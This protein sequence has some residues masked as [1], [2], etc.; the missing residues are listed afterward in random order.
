MSRGS[1]AVSWFAPETWAETR[2]A[3]A[4][5]DRLPASHAAWA[6]SALQVAGE[7]ERVGFTVVRI[8]IEAEPFLD[9]CEAQ[10]LPPDGRA[11]SRYAHERAGLP[12]PG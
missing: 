4:D 5:R 11:R 9:W 3:M 8:A 12:P 6:A 7:L 1:I 10:G 2:A